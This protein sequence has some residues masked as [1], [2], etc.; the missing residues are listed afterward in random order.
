MKEY[1]IIGLFGIHGL[2]N[3]GCE[4]IVRGTYKFITKA[5]TN[6]KIIL[7][8]GNPESDKKIIKDLD[9]NV[10]QIPLNKNIIMRRGINKI[11]RKCS[12]DYQLAIWNAKSVAKECDI[13]FSIG[14]DILTIPKQILENKNEK[15]Y[16]R[17]VQFGNYILKYKPYIIWGASIGPFGDNRRVNNYY[18]KHLNKVT[19]VF[20]REEGTYNYLIN[21]NIYRNI[22]LCSDP[23][24]YL[25]DND[26]KYKNKNFCKIRIALNL[27][28]LSIS[29]EVGNTKDNLFL[30]KIISTIQNLLSIPDTEIVLVPHV[31]SPES[32]YD[33]DLDFMEKIH[34][35]FDH[36]KSLYILKDCNGF[37]ATKKYLKSCDIVIAARMHC[38]I[39]A[40]SEG[41]PTI[42]LCY[43][44]K[45]FGMANYIYGDYNWAISLTNIE[46]ELKNKVLDMISNKEVITKHI[47]NRIAEISEDESRV[48]SLLRNI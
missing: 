36:N 12:I 15:V 47:Q 1:S 4:A 19:Q 41:I 22:Q 48:I 39:N 27:S 26:N 42:F 38:A 17:I 31:K 29:E 25:A 32:T 30:Q 21:N 6:Y 23:A 34:N 40:I 35:S 16:N 44:Q 14:G 24:F 18:F 8:T 46:L 10:K 20:C 7:Y 2:Y 9:I 11:L 43:S 3:Y 33:N 45:G 28:P 37:L 5:Y 13:V